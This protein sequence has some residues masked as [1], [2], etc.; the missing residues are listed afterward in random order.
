RP[1]VILD[2]VGHHHRRARSGE[3]EQRLKPVSPSQAS[4]Q[5]SERLGLIA[6]WLDG[7]LEVELG[8][9]GWN[10]TG[11]VRVRLSYRYRLLAKAI[12]QKESGAHSSSTVHNPAAI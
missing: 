3:A 5:V 10:I 1:A 12:S 2:D 4:R 9:H 11:F 7:C 8:G 6:G